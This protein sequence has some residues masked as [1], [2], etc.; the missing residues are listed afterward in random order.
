MSECC[1]CLRELD[2]VDHYGLHPE[3]FAAWYSC[4]PTEEI[5][6]V[7]PR[8]PESDDVPKRA[9][10]FLHGKFRKFTARIGE[11]AYVLKVIEP[12]YPN[13]PRVEYICNQI[14]EI[15]GL[16]VPAFSFLRFDGQDCFASR[17]FVDGTKWKKLTHIYHY[18]TPKE[19]FDVETLSNT[20]LRVTGKPQDV[21]RFHSI[22]LF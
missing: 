13:L 12:D 22:L 1:K 4:S 9:Q 17:N 16:S 21:N 10:T 11:A 2:G 3:C 15:V 7:T 19:E 6:E 8:E 14:A 20:I 18:L 5:R